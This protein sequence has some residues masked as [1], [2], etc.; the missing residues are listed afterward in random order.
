MDEKYLD[1]LA[2]N[3]ELWDLYTCKNE[4]SVTSPSPKYQGK[5]TESLLVPKI[6][7]HLKNNGF[8]V[9]YPEGKNF[10]ICLSHDVDDIY[11]PLSHK[12]LAGLYSLKNLD[13]SQLNNYFFREHKERRFS[14]YINFQQII[15]LEKKYGAK[16]TFY[17]MATDRDPRRFRYNIEDIA[18]EIQEI[19]RQGWDIGLHGGYYSFNDPEAIRREKDRLEDALQA[20]VPGYRNH[21]LRFLVPETWNIL[22]HCG[23]KFDSTYGHNNAVGFRNGTCHPFRPFNLNTHRPLEIYEIPLHIMDGTLFSLYPG[24]AAWSTMARLVD[25]AEK[26]YGVLTVLWHNNAFNCPFTSAW[27]KAYEQLLEYGLRKNAWMTSHYELWKWWVD[28][29][30]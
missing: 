4:Y 19:H 28:H 2:K 15:E 29:G 8:R 3:P 26:C 12:V 25:E 7:V 13:T 11:P 24:Y 17:L 16:S 6:S 27:Q 20:E 9:T 23:F 1:I 21:Y 14:P 18:G 22:Q 10:A 30:Y 5:S